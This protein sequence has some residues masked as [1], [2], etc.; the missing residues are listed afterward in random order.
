MST[1]IL[2]VVWYVLYFEKNINYIMFSYVIF[3]LWGI[4]LLK[5]LFI[6]HFTFELDLCWLLNLKIIISN[7]KLFQIYKFWYF[8]I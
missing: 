6:V 8:K 2:L 7:L 3:N 5:K 1:T 4:Y